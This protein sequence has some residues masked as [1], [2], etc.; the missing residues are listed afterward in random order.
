MKHFLFLAF[1]LFALGALAQNTARQKVIFDCDLGDDI[2]D[3]FALAL[4]LTN[5]DKLEILGIT[6]CYGRTDDRARVALKMLYETGQDKIP[7][8]LGRN[9][10]ASS[11]RANWYAEQF[12]W[13]KGFEKLQPSKQTA[14]DFILENLKKYPNEVVI[15]SVGPV[16][17]LADVLQKD[18]NALKMAKKIYAMFGSFYVSYAGYPTPEVEWNVRCDIEAAKKFVNSGANIAYA[19]LDITAFVK[20]DK[21]KRE[22]LLMRQSPLTNAISALYVLWGNETPTLFDPVAIGMLLYPDLFKSKKVNVSVDDQG[23][24]K[25]DETKSP[26]AEVGVYINSNEFIAKAMKAYLLQNMGRY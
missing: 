6:T 8:C 13:A 18:P 22:T 16:T 12:Y 9:T 23:F 2:D 7:V 14:A 1:L 10:S 24:T 4:L 3:A 20:L 11:E 25:V 15:I 17:N 26:N 19:G 21:A 5:Q